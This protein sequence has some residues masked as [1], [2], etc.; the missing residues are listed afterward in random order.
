[1]SNDIDQEK[2]GILFNNNESERILSNIY[3]DSI[4]NNDNNNN[5]NNNNNNV[6]NLIYKIQESSIK[7][8]KNSNDFLSQGLDINQTQER[9]YPKTYYCKNSN[10]FP[11]IKIIVKNKL[12]FYNANKKIGETDFGILTTFLIT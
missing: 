3:I 11:E 2:F 7:P 12:I 9:I 5:D 6:N 1:M 8:Q 10:S 4:N